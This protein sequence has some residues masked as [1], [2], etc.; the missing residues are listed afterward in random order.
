MSIQGQ[1]DRISSNIA[2]AYRIAQ[3]EGITLPENRNS[4]NLPTLINSLI[5]DNAPDFI[6]DEAERVATR[7]Q[8]AQATDSLIFPILSDFHVWDESNESGHLATYTSM[9]YASMG[10]AELK[11]HINFDFVGYLGDYSWMNT[12]YTAEQVMCDITAV[13]ETIRTESTEIWCVGNHDLNYGK[14]RDRLLTLDEMYSYIG[15]NSD[16]IKPNENI[17]RCYGYLDFEN[18]K[19]RVIYLNT[20]DASDLVVPETGN[21]SSEWVSPTQIQWLADTALNFSSKEN[22]SDWGIVIVGHHPLHYPIGC[23]KS[24]M[25][26]LEAYKDGLSGTLSCTIRTDTDESGNKTYPQQKVTYDF[27]TGERAKIICN[28]HGHAHN[29][30][31]SKISST[32]SSGSTAVA[33]WLWRFCIPQICSTRNNTG[34]ENFK[35][36]ETHAKN[37][38]EF[39]DDG[40]TPK[41]WDKETGNAKATSFCVIDINRNKK[42]V[43]AYY[44][45]V[46]KDR[47]FS[48]DEEYV[49]QEFNVNVTVDNCTSNSSNPTTITEGETATLL[50]TANEGYVLPDSV[51]VTGASYTWDKTT[52]TL[53]LSVPT[54][55]VSVIVTAIEVVELPYTNQIPTSTDTDGSVYNGTGYKKDTC[56]ST[57]GADSAKT[58]Y[59]ATGFIPIPDISTDYNGGHIILRLKNTEAD[60]GAYTRICFYDS[61][62]T[63][64][65]LL[66]GTN[67]AEGNQTSANKDTYNK[68]SDGYLAV[69]DI[70]D[71]IWYLKASGKG[72]T[73]YIRFCCAGI[74]SDS[75]ITVNEIID[76]VPIVPSYTVTNNLSNVVNSNTISTIAEGETYTATLTASNGYTMDGATV[77]ITM[78][79]T[80]VT[81][82]VYTSGVV[83]VAN[84]TGDIII[85]AS[86][87][88]MSG[89]TN[90]L[91]LATTSPTDNTIYGEDYNGDG[92][93]DGYK[94]D[95]RYSSSAGGLTSG[96]GYQ[97]TGLIPTS[98]GDIVRI[99]N[100]TSIQFYIYVKNDGSLGAQTP[101]NCYADGYSQPDS[102]GVYTFNA[103]SSATAGWVGVRFSCKGITDN[104]IITVNEPIE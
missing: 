91:P 63:Y 82:T 101:S 71:Y 18:Q 45:G 26:L 32:T 61:S 59:V 2:S 83:S 24:V 70:S 21:A 69:I 60:A 72:T 99:K 8:S 95:I 10:I 94:K 1:I 42:K 13:K 11:K 57:S 79:G 40:I 89:Y 29:Y 54:S 78:G 36:N 19:I 17:N 80:D 16:G 25:T 39:E 7:I 55:D 67:L 47:E 23:F 31:S 51:S 41:Y 62:K 87:V 96:T 81:S 85:T 9:R 20:C 22:A 43:F 73:A 104:T 48:Y 53:T 65:G 102:N 35:N 5:N 75:V 98:A 93:N 97:V 14:D 33:P 27:S 34:Y 84:V 88:K 3:R 12:S 68:G 50:F 4:D 37:Y 103:P 92:V 74:D 6:I 66:Y 86:A 56:L 100:V 46:G 64:L 52:G 49:A 28:I 76:D 77:T 30:A 44:F 15:A 58:G 90:L 38:G